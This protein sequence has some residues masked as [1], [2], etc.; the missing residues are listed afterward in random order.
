MDKPTT[1]VAS[2]AAQPAAAGAHATY[3]PPRLTGKHALEQVTLFS[4]A[5]KPGDPGCGVGHP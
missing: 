3:Q 5:C 4:F 2:P 1:H